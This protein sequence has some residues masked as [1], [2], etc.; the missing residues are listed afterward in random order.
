MPT[1]A[2]VREL[3]DAG[4]SYQTVG[5]VLHIPP[6]QAFMIATGVPADGSDALHPDELRDKPDLPASSQDLVNPAPVSPTR[7]E[8]VV[9]WV[10]ARAARELGQES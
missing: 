4:H 7:D 5:R 10:A 9:A 6:G 2:Q 8:T 3:L 1:R